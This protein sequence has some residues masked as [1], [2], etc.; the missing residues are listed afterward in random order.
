MT[1]EQKHIRNLINKAFIWLDEFTSSYADLRTWV[2]VTAL[3]YQLWSSTR[4]LEHIVQV[5]IE[6]YETAAP[7]DYHLQSKFYC[8]EHFANGHVVNPKF[9]MN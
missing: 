8:K 1:K 3:S 4:H 9:P 7:M 6:C 2:D 5:S